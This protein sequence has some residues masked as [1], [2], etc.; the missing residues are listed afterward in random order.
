MRSPRAE[1]PPADVW[2]VGKVTLP[3]PGKFST[4]ALSNTVG[5]IPVTIQSFCGAGSFDFSNGVCFA[6]TPWTN[7][8][9][10]LFSVTSVRKAGSTTTRASPNVT[11]SI[12]HEDLSPDRQLMV[13][14]FQNGELIATAEDANSD[15]RHFYYEPLRVRPGANRAA[16]NMPLE[17]EIIIQRGVEFE[18]LVDPKDYDAPVT[19]L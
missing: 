5:G 4:L 6:G 13:R 9:S 14:F 2:K 17:M 16:T 8:M 19:A 12:E 15:G 7:G 1:F 10:S 3:L 11:L 18:F